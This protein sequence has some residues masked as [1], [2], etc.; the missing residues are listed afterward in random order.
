VNGEEERAPQIADAT[1]TWFDGLRAP[2]S[3]G[4]FGVESLT[5]EIDE[6]GRRIVVFSGSY[7]H[8]EF[9]AAFD[10]E[11]LVDDLCQ[12]MIGHE[13][14]LRPAEV[15]ERAEVYLSAYLSETAE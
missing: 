15:P 10:R 2:M 13:P 3:V 12:A 1:K 14:P 6:H 11:G 9:E 8:G 5:T 4:W 7:P